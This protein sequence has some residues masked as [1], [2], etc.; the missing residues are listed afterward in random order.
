MLSRVFPKW[1]K[2]RESDKLVKHELGKF[3][4][5]ICHMYLVGTTVESWSLAQEATG[6]NPLAVMTNICSH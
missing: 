4:D 3:K 1:K 2:I 5:P 6:L